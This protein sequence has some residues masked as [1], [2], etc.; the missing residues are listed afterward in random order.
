MISPQTVRFISGEGMPR[1]ES[2]GVTR[3]R[4]VKDLPKGDLYVKFNIVF[5]AKINNN[6]RLRIIEALE[7][8]E[9][10]LA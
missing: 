6:A 4:S 7:K 9:L 1:A 8:N 3:L 2:D 10:E 5:P